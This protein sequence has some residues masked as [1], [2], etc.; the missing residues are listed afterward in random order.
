MLAELETGLV[1]RIRSAPVAQRVREVDALPELD[2]A[3]LV[4]KFGAS[5]P[6]IYVSPASFSIKDQAQPR[7]SVAAVSRNAAGHK[8]AMQGDGRLIG[9]YELTDALLALLNGA[10]AGGTSWTVR[11]VDF[12]KD[13]QLYQAGLH[14]AVLRL[15][16]TPVQL[17]S[18][19]DD[20][21]LDDFITFHGDYDIEPFETPAEHEK[22]LQEPPDHTGSAPDLTDQ[23][24]L[25]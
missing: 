13:E 24:Q 23:L 12:V 7:F 5:A 21:A 1:D 15:E 22:W 10:S 19:L 11:G 16:G 8:G 14:V 3:A 9:L 2:G 25:R 17:P 6:A 18:F 20:A 4:K